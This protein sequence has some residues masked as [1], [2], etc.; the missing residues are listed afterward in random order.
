MIGLLFRTLCGG[1]GSLSFSLIGIGALCGGLCGCMQA[2][3][4][5]NFKLRDIPC[6]KWFLRATGIDRHGDFELMLMVH[7]VVSDFKGGLKCGVKVTAGSHIVR[8]PFSG[9]GIFHCSLR[10]YVEQGTPQLS[11]DLVT[12]GDVKLAQL[13]LNVSRDILCMASGVHAEKVYT[14]R[15]QAK[16]LHHATVRLSISICTPDDEDAE[17]ADTNEQDAISFMVQNAL[18]KAETEVTGSSTHRESLSEIEVCRH[19]CAGPVEVFGELGKCVPRYLGLLGPPQARRFFLGFWAN[20]EE[21]LKR[22]SPWKEIDVMK[23]SSVQPDPVREDVFVISYVD[24]SRLTHS[25]YMRI[26]DRPSAVWVELLKL[27]VSK[28]HQFHEE[29][30][31]SKSLKFGHSRTEVVQSKRIS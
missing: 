26:V 23:I 4:C 29:T 6:V 14:M 27:A 2:M 10:V 18:Q 22:N 15:P 5:S 21:F 11:V 19:A 3:R 7:E 16:T 30:K 8:T 24:A 20:Q 12:K 31:R 9:K 17:A 28:A 1:L 13:K 25:L